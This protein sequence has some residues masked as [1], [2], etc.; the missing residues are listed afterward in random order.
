MS[1]ENYPGQQPT[2]GAGPDPQQPTQ[3]VQPV[4]PGQP[5][6][7]AWGA[8]ESAPTEWVGSGQPA[9]GDGGT[10]GPPAAGQQESGSGG[11]RRKGL[12]VGAIVAV[13][14][15]LIA[16]GSFAA[17][18][19]LS[20]G[21]PQPAEAIPSSAIAYTRI[22]LDPSADQKI[23]ALRLLRNVPDF[24]EETGITSDTDD[25][26]KRLFEEALKDSEGCQDIDYDDDIAP[27]IGERAGVAALPGDEGEDP[28]GYVALQVTDEDAARTG[29]EKLL[30][31]GAAEETGE[32]NA[33]LA[34]VGDYAVIADEDKVDDYAADAEESPLSDDDDFN[35]DIDALDGEGLMSFWVDLDAFVELAEQESPEVGDALEAAG[36]DELGSVSAAVRAQ[37]DAIELVMAANGDLMTFG[38]GSTEPATD[39]QTLPD[40]TM[41]AFGF[42]GGGDSVDKLWE[43]LQG[44]E[45]SGAA[46]LPPGTLEQMAAQIEAESGFAVPDDLSV[47]LGEQFTLAV[48]G[49]GF[50]FVDDEGMPDFGNINVGARMVTDVDAVTSL[51]DKVQTLLAQQGAPFQIAQEEVDDGLVIAANED[52]AEAL[53]SEGQL[54]E[55]DVFQSAVAGGD[56]STA[57]FFLDLD[58]VAEVAQRLAEDAGQGLSEDDMDTLDAFRAVGASTVPDG[59]YS[60]TTF[61]VVFD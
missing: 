55:S 4:Q 19:I 40:T 35:A 22:D 2:P 39:V 61:R 51:V 28:E 18:T 37:S 34:F 52:Y 20:G 27:W 57:V 41:M 45:D 59:D 8:P 9:A 16:G 60:V 10:V 46:G 31:C 25:L 11:G 38:G 33:G 26:R 56:D 42:T 12:V 5:P 23:N 44:L 13:V 49:E 29:I 1:N 17:Y 24:E 3:P 48:D 36:I 30:E 7:Q 47:L 53:A 32:E 15:V 21:G 14:V 58:R 50:D 54:G 43:D 6:A